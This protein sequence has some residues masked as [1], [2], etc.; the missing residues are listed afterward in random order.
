MWT[1]YFKLAFRNIIRQKFYTAINVTGLAIG[2]A[3]CLLILL[4]VKDE[5]SYDRYHSKSDR[6]YRILTEWKQSTENNKTPINSYRMAPALKND[7]PEFEQVI[8]F[9]P[10]SGLLRYEDKEYQEDRVFFV[11]PE[12][13]E[14]FDFELISGDPKTALLEPFTILLSE[15]TAEKYFPNENPVGKALTYNNQGEVRVTGVFKDFPINSHFTADIFVSMETGKQVFNTLILN[16]WGEL[17]QYTYL[18]L[19]EQVDPEQINARFPEFLEKNWGEGSSEGVG[20]SLQPLTSIHLHSNHAAEI[21]ANSDIKYIYIA[22]AI[23]LFIILIACINYMN[24]ATA[25]SVKRAMEIG[26]RKTLGAPRGSLIGQFLS[27]SVLLAFIAFL[28]GL[29]LVQLVLPAFNNFVD[30]SLA[31]NPIGNANVLILFMAITL[32]V[33]LI[34]GSYPAFYLS[35]FQAVKVFRQKVAKRSAST[36][37]RKFLV[38]F[39]FAISIILI[40]ST[41]IIYSQW[42]YLRNKNLGYNR[43]NL[44]LVPIPT[45]DD[46]PTLKEQLERNPNVLSVTAS[47]KRLTNSLSSNLGFEAELYEQDPQNRSSIKV[48][49]V[50]VDFM[51]TLEAEMVEGRNFSEEFG[52]DAQEAFILN[53]AAVKMIGWEEPIGKTFETSE[54]APEGWQERKGKSSWRG[55]RFQYGIP[56]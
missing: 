41:M 32:V 13:F 24:L 43:D 39:Q 10:A 25:R 49:T 29:L 55:K 14:V 23:A 16:N 3:V 26:V 20:L 9:S 28:L 33:G 19:P 5:I 47:N 44:V 21:E 56:L 35:S 15:T 52:A 40:I 48:V 30:K 45:T 36:Y 50:D 27:E 6:I 4:F 7:F 8:R 2:L 12:V 46:Y 54:F 42:D 11:D 17:S 53:E 51:N 31:I 1:N 34:A 37:M 22:S 38:I 18:L